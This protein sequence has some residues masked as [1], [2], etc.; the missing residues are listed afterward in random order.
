MIRRSVSFL[1]FFVT[2]PAILCAG[3]PF[4]LNFPVI[5]DPEPDQWGYLQSITQV[6]ASL[7]MA[8]Q[9][10]LPIKWRGRMDRDWGGSIQR[11]AHRAMF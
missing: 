10:R 8:F 7:E 6:L 5:P 9:A 2:F 4:L 3:N 11:Q 1:V